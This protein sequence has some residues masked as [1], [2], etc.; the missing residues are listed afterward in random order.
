[1]NPTL[2]RG[3]S[4]LLLLSLAGLVIG[5]AAAFIW[6]PQAAATWGR[7]PVALGARAAVVG[8]AL[9]VA[10]LRPQPPALH[11]TPGGPVWVSTWRTDDRTTAV[12][13]DPSGRLV[14]VRQEPS[15]LVVDVP[16]EGLRG[17]L[18]TFGGSLPPDVGHL[19]FAPTGD[20]DAI[21]TRPDG[22]VLRV[23]APRTGAAG[24]LEIRGEH[25]LP[26][27]A[28]PFR[29]PSAV[30]VLATFSVVVMAIGLLWR[31]VQA[32]RAHPGKAVWLGAAV[33]A[34]TLAGC[35][36]RAVALGGWAD[37]MTASVAMALGMAMAV[38]AGHTLD[39]SHGPP[40]RPSV[41][42]QLRAGW[43]L[44]G[45]A[46]GAASVSFL[47][48]GARLMGVTAA[49]VT[50]LAPVWAVLLGT[51][52]SLFV[53]GGVRP[54]VHRLLPTST[55]HVRLAAVAVVAALATAGV[56]PQPW[57]WAL[58][59]MILACIASGLTAER[60]GQAAAFVVLAVFIA[61]CI[62]LPGLATS[63]VGGVASAFGIVLTYA[64]GPL[65][66]F[67]HG[68]PKHDGSYVPEYVRALR[69]EARREYVEEVA[70]GLQAPLCVIAPAVD[71][72][73]DAACVVRRALPPRSDFCRIVGIT[74]ERVGV[75]VGE[76]PGGG[77]SGALQASVVSTA[78]V[79]LI[80]DAKSLASLPND[81]E[82][83][84]ATV[85][86][87]DGDTVCM[88]IGILDGR[89]KTFSLA[90]AGG[91]AVLLHRALA[92]R[93][94][95]VTVAG[96]PLRVRAPEG[97]RVSEV[98]TVQ[99]V[100]KDLLIFYSNGLLGVPQPGGTPFSVA[101][102]ES[103]VL[104]NPTASC[105]ALAEALEGKLQSLLDGAPPPDDIVV[106]FLRG[107]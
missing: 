22:V 65:F 91:Q 98:A 84:S 62:A 53:E 37:G 81:V 1:M 96:A 3:D 26:S 95:H 30:A 73:L 44:G 34:T 21:L 12:A 64:V 58:L 75:I 50:G 31:T 28:G 72:G 41:G 42:A 20:G 61:A 99:L 82:R 4:R 16:Q 13:L 2:H 101:D 27:L 39:A 97:K 15:M 17:W 63:A 5:L 40:Q 10:G 105:A 56:V 77:V 86:T 47:L 94:E 100:T 85:W 89:S 35:L 69:D 38:M 11:R 90:N 6:Y 102:L 60:F 52:C 29:L 49:R 93:F 92:G 32:G 68:V 55:M 70:C 48:P 66:I 23:T 25:S 103:L 67:R 24:P 87:G 9:G 106:L 8:R 45:A 76:V 43:M 7:G 80:S 46:L 104:T 79:A 51:A 19:T 57:W 71:R 74:K 54:V 36:A 33:A 59:W 14:A 83:A 78:T 88:G 18:E 107:K